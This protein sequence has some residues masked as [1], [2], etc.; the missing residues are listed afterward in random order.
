MGRRKIGDLLRSAR[1]FRGLSQEE[2]ATLASSPELAITA[3]AISSWE[4]GARE[5]SGSRLRALA[6]VISLPDAAI[7]AALK[8]EE[9][10]P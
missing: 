3:R 4:T 8:T 9:E 5:L 7:G 1:R 10:A 2:L 6:R